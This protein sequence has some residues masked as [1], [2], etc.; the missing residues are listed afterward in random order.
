[1]K[2]AMVKFP[3]ATDISSLVINAVVAVGTV[4]GGI[5]E[6]TGIM[7]NPPESTLIAHTHSIPSEGAVVSI[8]ATVTGPAVP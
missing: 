3:D 6:F 4:A 7:Q 1:M 8:P 5:V 2:Y